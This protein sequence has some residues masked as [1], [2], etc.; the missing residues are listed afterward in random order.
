[1]FTVIVTISLEYG[2]IIVAKSFGYGTTLLYGSMNYFKQGYLED[3]DVITVG[4]LT[5][6]Y[7][8]IDSDSWPKETKEKAKADI[9]AIM[10]FSSYSF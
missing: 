3:E 4:E 6:D 5:K 1:M 2:Y 10:S 9:S 8:D 7:T